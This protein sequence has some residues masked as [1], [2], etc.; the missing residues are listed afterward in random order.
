MFRFEPPP[1]PRA[2]GGVEPQDPYAEPTPTERPIPPGR[3]TASHPYAVAPGAPWGPVGQNNH[4]SGTAALVLGIL[5]C[6][7]L[8]ILGPIAWV[9]ARSAIRESQASPY[10]VTN[11]GQLTAARILGIVGTGMLVLGF[12]WTVILII[13]ASGLA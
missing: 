2:G 8:A 1:T 6:C 7:G 9:M 4:P 12:L 3:P 5:S 11:Y 10:A 13:I